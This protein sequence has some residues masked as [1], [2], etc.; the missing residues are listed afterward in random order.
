MLLEVEKKVGEGKER[1][2][3]VRQGGKKAK[4]QVMSGI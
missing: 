4:Q 1:W 2:K 3:K